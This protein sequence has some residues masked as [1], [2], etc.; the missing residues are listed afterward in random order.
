MVN[1]VITK[2]FKAT[3][4]AAAAFAAFTTFQVNADIVISGTRIVYPQSSKDVIVNLDNR[5]N[6]PLLVQTWLD[7]GRDGVNPQEL[8]LP[9]V[10]TPPVSRIDPQ[11]GQ[12]L[13][14][15]Y[16]GS[17]LPQDRES[18]FW[19]NVLEIPPKSKAKEGESL[20]QL[21]LAFRTRIKLFFRPDGL[22]GTPG[23][24]ATNLKWSQ[25]KEGNTLSL[26]AQND[27]PY[28][29]SVSNVKL[30]VGSKEYTVDSKSVLPFSGVSMPVKGLSNNISGTVIYN[31]I[32]DNGGTD[33]R[34]AKID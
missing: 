27:S 10:I 1:M 2:G 18:L 13:R 25:K 19:F 34:E 14:I 15:T 3:C 22:K 29:V 11:K 26:F 4:F 5:G 16:M 30:K 6:K 23:D 17:T 7:D 32:N 33:K 21:Q 20:N 24:A 9:F 31:T 8:K 28:N 12:S